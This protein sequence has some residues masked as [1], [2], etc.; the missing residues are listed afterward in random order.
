MQERC[1]YMSLNE[2]IFNVET[3]ETI[4]REYSDEEKAI[5]AE[6][7]KKIEAEQAEIAKREQIRQ[8]ALA[9]LIDLGLTEEEIA[10]L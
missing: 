5:A 2:K 1:M 8:T 9:K 3:G 7:R 4:T 10:A 6:W